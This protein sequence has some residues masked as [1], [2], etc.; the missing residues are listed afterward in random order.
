MM[1]NTVDEICR[2]VV[3]TKHLIPTTNTTISSAYTR[4][5]NVEMPHLIRDNVISSV[6]VF[7]NVI[8]KR[9]LYLNPAA[10]TANVINQ[11]NNKTELTSNILVLRQ[12]GTLMRSNIK[13]ADYYVTMNSGF[14]VVLD[15]AN[16]RTLNAN[17]EMLFR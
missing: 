4:S 1:G 5:T 11:V 13:A 6:I 15:G 2:D 12:D 3:G 17:T 16:T 14:A 7:N 10:D 8:T 9:G